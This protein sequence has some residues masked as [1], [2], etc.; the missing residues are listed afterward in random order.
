MQLRRLVAASC[1]ALA[2]AAFS[3][4]VAAQSTSSTIHACVQQP[5]GLVRIVPASE[6]CRPGESRITW[7]SGSTADDGETPAPVAP[8]APPWP[9]VFDTGG[10][11]MTGSENL[12]LQV[13]GVL[14]ESLDAR[15][16]DW[17]EIEA[18]SFGAARVFSAW[19]PHANADSAG[20]GEVIVLKYLDRASADLLRMSIEGRHIMQVLIEAYRPEADAKALLHLRLEDVVVSS[21]RHGA[22]SSQ[23][24]PLEEVGFR[25]RTKMFS[26][27]CPP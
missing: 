9:P 13:D 19:D 17:I 3:V 27:T 14:G 5:T 1:L 12:Y 4:L 6:V 21:F 2:C 23:P 11:T 25:L 22:R 16:K 15:H 7:N 20:I 18:T 24:R 26:S 8:P 10:L